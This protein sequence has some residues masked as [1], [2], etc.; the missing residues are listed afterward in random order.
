MK[1]TPT[2]P[3]REGGPSEITISARLLGNGR[4]VLPPALARYLLRV[5]LIAADTTRM[6]ELAVKNQEGAL[7]PRR[8]RRAGK[9]WKSRLS[10][11]HLAIEGS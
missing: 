7:T 3:A 10:A 9:L 11:R 2:A 5:G 1:T 4:E 8:A 6:D